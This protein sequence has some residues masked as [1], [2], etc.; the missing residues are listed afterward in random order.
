MKKAGY[1]LQLIVF[2]FILFSCHK[3]EINPIGVHAEISH[4]TGFH[5]NDGKIDLTVTGGIKPIKFLWSNNAFTEDLDSLAAGTYSVIISDR[6]NTQVLDT[7][8]ILEPEPDPMFITFETTFPTN[9]GGSDGKATATVNGGYPPY[10]YLW[11]NGATTPTIENIPADVYWLT[12]TDDKNF[13][14]TDTVS[15]I[16]FI[17]DSEGNKYGFIVFGNQV[18]LKENLQVTTT[19]DGKPIESFVYNNNE[20]NA[21]IY[22]RLYTWDVAMNGSRQEKAQGVCPSGWH[23]PSDSEFKELEMFLG[24]SANEANKE[25]AWRGAGIGT[26]LKKEGSSKYNAPMGGRRFPDG[27]FSQLNGVEYIW[28]STEANDQAAWRRTLDIN[29]DKVGRFN[30]APKN[31]A[32]SIR[33]IKN[34]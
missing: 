22:G 6:L 23:I 33:C 32:Y 34:K 8:I 19:A 11:S 20:E 7:F 27:S 30:T 28:T 14:V 31:Y 17:E 18:W 29:S 15:L 24:M 2:V 9:T 1:K 5:R 13:T 25:N 26:L 3:D 10:S 12:I 21:S 16:D 4:V